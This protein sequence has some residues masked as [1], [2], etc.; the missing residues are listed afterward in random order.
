VA[1]LKDV[2]TVWTNIKEIDLKPIRD[3]ATHPVRIAIVGEQGVGRHTLA[4][5]MRTDPERPEI[6]TQTAIIFPTMGISEE[7]PAAHLTIIMLDAT[8]GDFSLEQA[9]VKS[10][11]DAGKNVLVFINKIDLLENNTLID[12]QM[13]WLS[14]RIIYGSA[15]D[16]AYLLREF[17]PVM[18]ELLP[19]Q[20]LA[21]G[22]QF[23]LFRITIARQII[24]DTCF[25]NA[26]YS[27]STGLA[28][29]VPVL[30]IPL[31]LTDMI[32]LTKTQAFLAYKLGLLVGFSTNWQEYVTEFGGVIGGG[33]VWRQIAR[34]FIGLIPGWGIIP[35]VAVAYS[36]T[37]VVGHAVLG[38]YLTGKHLSP[39]QMR[40]LSRQALGRGKD[41][42]RRLGEKLPNPKL[43]KHRETKLLEPK[44]MPEFNLGE[45]IVTT[46]DG[47]TQ[48]IPVSGIS[49]QQVYIP[50]TEN[51]SQK[52]LDPITH[53]RKR[54]QLSL[55]KK[56]KASEPVN[57]RT[58]LQCGKTSS[59]DAGFCQYCGTH[60][61]N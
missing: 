26:A 22:R 15:N 57:T 43:G 34:Q 19:Q 54:K 13:G 47:I 8:R 55:R 45:L 2:S 53:Q 33:F 18:L 58:C 7:A 14:S 27:L 32:V 31:N 39:K 20:H 49:T 48:V 24:N 30:N 36:G 28:E 25:S 11:S 4:E 29:I 17:V 12:P 9:L 40:A 60:F 42:A 38:W 37:Y 23:P 59:A 16:S 61:E 21:L 10:W 41:Y 46:D 5:Q 35:K 44:V 50:K 51:T 3:S 1:G 56:K 52:P 6:H